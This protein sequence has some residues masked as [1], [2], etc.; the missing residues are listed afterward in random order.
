MIIHRISE[1]SKYKKRIVILSLI[2]IIIVE[3]N[4]KNLKTTNMFKDP[5]IEQKEIKFVGEPESLEVYKDRIKTNKT[6]L[7]K[8]EIIY[9]ASFY[10]AFIAMKS[11]IDLDSKEKLR[12]NITGYKVYYQEHLLFQLTFTNGVVH[13]TQS[14]LRELLTIFYDE[15]RVFCR[16]DIEN[17]FIFS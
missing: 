9:L 4:K 1:K 5:E 14:C 3:V 8:T 13:N 15:M 12:L 7:E 6:L 10:D 11:H 17:L 16:K 2:Y